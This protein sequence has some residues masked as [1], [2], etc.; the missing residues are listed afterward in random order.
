M[1]PRKP[2]AA[3]RFQPSPDTRRLQPLGGGRFVRVFTPDGPAVVAPR[4]HVARLVVMF[5]ADDRTPG[6][7]RRELEADVESWADVIADLADLEEASDD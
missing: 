2:K 3:D 6:W 1:A 7:L 5:D 4:S